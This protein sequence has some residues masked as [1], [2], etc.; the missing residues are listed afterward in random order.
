MRKLARRIVTLSLAGAAFPTLVAVALLERIRTV[1]R[2]R[3]APRPRLIWGP[4]PL[5]QI[6]YWSEAMRRRGYQSVSC[7]PTVYPA[8]TRDD[9]DVHRDEFLGSGRL[10][11]RVRDYAVFVW[12]LR[13]GDVFLRF[14]DGGYLRD[15]PLQWWEA[16]LLRLAGKKLI[17]SSYGADIAVPGYLGDIEEVTFADYPALRAQGSLTARWVR[18]SL[19]WADVRIRTITV[20]FLP[21]YDVAW[22]TQLGI[23][24]DLWRPN[25]EDSGSD[26]RNTDVVVLHAP[27]HRRINGTHHLQE[28][29]SRLLDEGLK[30]DLRILEGRP[31]EEIR[32]AM[33]AADIVA[34]Q[35]LDP[36]YGMFPIEAM[37][38]GK[39]MLKRMSPIPEELRTEVLRACPLVDANPDNLQDQ[40]RRLVTDPVLRRELG[41]AGRDFVIHNHSHEAVGRDWEVVIEHAWRGAPLP[42]RLKPQKTRR[43]QL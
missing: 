13:H 4:T 30:I 8:F 43:P 7:V 2:R 3:M 18:H 42:D 35:F 11:E 32:A 16:P 29:V 41:H 14:Y 12:T 23:D 20:G 9:F 25:G 31:N 36:G 15:T 24:T 40:L 19:R 6:K 1:S 39:P 17:V 5:I 37:A 10:A 22:L 21:A 33:H 28:A 38:V 27:N 34:D 26:G